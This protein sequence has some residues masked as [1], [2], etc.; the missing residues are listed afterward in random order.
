MRAALLCLAAELAGA[1]GQ[2]RYGASTEKAPSLGPA[3]SIRAKSPALNYRSWPAAPASTAARHSNA[4]RMLFE[5]FPAGSVINSGTPKTK[6][7]KGDRQSASTRAGVRQTPN[8]D[9]LYGCC[10]SL[11]L[12]RLMALLCFTR[13]LTTH[14][15]LCL[16]VPALSLYWL[17]L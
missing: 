2:L 15:V 16:Y 17:R 10:T 9:T 13:T 1:A 8:P 6:H 12:T 11:I 7:Q 5:R 3:I 4:A 14:E